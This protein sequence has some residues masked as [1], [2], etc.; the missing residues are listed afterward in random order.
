MVLIFF[1]SLFLFEKVD[2][3]IL[4]SFKKEFEKNILLQRR[5]VSNQ[6]YIKLYGKINKQSY[7]KVGWLVFDNSH[8]SSVGTYYINDNRM[9]QFD[10][11]LHFFHHAVEDDLVHNI[12]HNVQFENGRNRSDHWIKSPRGH[13][14]VNRED[15]AKLFIYLT[16]KSFY[17]GKNYS[18]TLKISIK[19]NQEGTWTYF[20]RCGHIF[21][22]LCANID[23]G[24]G[25]AK[26]DN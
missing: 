21:N 19:S 1:L 7:R 14:K 18:N 11:F 4:T 20:R 15:D 26:L 17:L 23:E 16:Y 9:R 8:F 12:N 5:K 6:V 13:I 22:K 3:P 2:N 10:Y 25:I 24:N